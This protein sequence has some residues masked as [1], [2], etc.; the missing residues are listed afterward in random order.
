MEIGVK[1]R[2][3]RKAKG[4]TLVEL[5]KLI[6]VSNAALSQIETGK[7]EPSRKTLIALG[8]ALNSN[9]G[10][11]WL[12]EHLE[13]SSP[14]PSKREI[15]KEM[16]ATELVALKF[17]GGETSSSEA[18]MLAKLLDE[19]LAKEERILSYPEYKPKE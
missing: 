6:D 9:F 18:R 2:E 1:I 11:D 16:T 13:G 5:G 17:G 7:T 3:V 14:A 15:A 19:A 10:L 8:K 12:D 4:F